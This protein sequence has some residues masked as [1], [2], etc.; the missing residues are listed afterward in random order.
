MS[1]L[2][3][4]CFY[5]PRLMFILLCCF[6]S[7]RNTHYTQKYDRPF[8]WHH[9]LQPSLFLLNQYFRAWQDFSSPMK[10]VG[11]TVSSSSAYFIIYSSFALLFCYFS[12]GRIKWLHLH[13]IIDT[14]WWDGWVPCC[15][16]LHFVWLQFSFVKRCHKPTCRVVVVY[17]FVSKSWYQHCIV[18]MHH[19]YTE[20]YTFMRLDLD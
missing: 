18:F 13:Y 3:Y 4:H 9:L 5:T 20:C 8:D 16:I 12:H 11:T 14:T 17:C 6:L 19:L 10:H 15:I 1:H 2:H 7:L